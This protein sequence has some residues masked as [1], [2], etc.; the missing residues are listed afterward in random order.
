MAQI[1]YQNPNGGSWHTAN[2]WDLKRV[3]GPG[4]DVEIPVFAGSPVISI[5][6]NTSVKSITTNESVRMSGGTL[7]FERIA[8]LDGS[9]SIDA[10]TLNGGVFAR[11]NLIVQGSTI[12]IGSMTIGYDAT[13]SIRDYASITIPAAG[14]VQVEGNANLAVGS[15]IVFYSYYN[16]QQ[17]KVIVKGTLTADRS[18]FTT[19][20][21]N[22]FQS[23]AITIE[24]GGRM[25]AKSSV[26]SSP[27]VTFKPGALIGTTDLVNN[28][29]DTSIF[30]AA[31][32]IDKL[33][34]ASG[35]SDNRSF[36]E[37]YIWNGTLST[38]ELSLNKI[39]KDNTENLVYGFHQDFTVGRNATLRV[40]NG[41][42]IYVMIG[43]RL[44]IEGEAIFGRGS[45]VAFRPNYSPQ[46]PGIFVTGKMTANSS[47]FTTK[48]PNNYANG[49]IT[50]ESGGQFTA[51]SC[52]F[53]GPTISLKLGAKIGAKDFV[54]NVFDASLYL[55]ATSID[56]F[57]SVSGGSDNRSFY[58]INFWAATLVS[59]ETLT[60]RKIGKLSSLNLKYVFFEQFVVGASARLIVDPDVSVQI[61]NVG[62]TINGDANFLKRT[63]LDFYAGNATNRPTLSVNGTLTV[64]GLRFIAG[65]YANS[66]RLVISSTGVLDATDST[67][68][69][70][71][72]QFAPGS[73]IRIRSQ[74]GSLF[75]LG[76]AGLNA[77][78]NEVDTFSFTGG[79]TAFVSQT[80]KL[81]PAATFEL[82]ESSLYST[83]GSLL[84]ESSSPNAF[85]P[86]GRVIF[87]GNSSASNP[88]FLE[89]P[90][91]DFLLNAA[92]FNP[93]NYLFGAIEIA[94][95]RYVKLIDDSDNA[96]GIG[97]EAVYTN[98]L[99][100]RSN[101]TLD[102]NSLSSLHLYA[103]SILVEAGGRIING[104][105]APILEDS[106]PLTLGV[107]TP[108]QIDAQGNFDR[109][110][111]SARAGGSVS[112]RLNPGSI[113][114]PAPVAPQLGF[115]R[116]LLLDPNNN[117]I[118][119][120]FGSSLGALANIASTVLPSEGIYTV[121]VSAPQTSTATGNYVLTASDTTPNPRD[122]AIAIQ[123]NRTS[124]MAY[125]NSVTFTTT[126]KPLA[127]SGPDASGTVQF[128]IDGVAVGSPI[129]LVNQSAAIS[130]PILVAGNRKVT[131]AYSG[132]GKKYDAKVSAE[133]TQ[134][135][136]KAILQVTVDSKSKTAGEAIPAL[137]YQVSG[138]VNSE[139][140]SVV[141]GTPALT[142]APEAENRAGNYIIYAFL[143][144]L[145]S[146]NYTFQF[147]NATLAVLPAS[148]ADLRITS[149][150]VQ[151][152]K[153]GRVFVAPL[154]VR[155][156]DRF[157]NPILGRIVTFIAPETGPSGS[158]A[159]GVRTISLA[160]NSNGEASIVQFT[161]NLTPGSFVLLAEMSNLTARFQLTNNEQGAPLELS[162]SKSSISEKNGTATG[163]LRRNTPLGQTM[164]V[165][166]SSSD[167]LQATVPQT[168]TFEANSD[169]VE[170]AL[171]AVDEDV[172]DGDQLVT[173]LAASATASTSTAILVVDDEKVELNLLFSPITIPENG[174]TSTGTVFRNTPTTSDLAVSLTSPDRRYVDFPQTV[175]ILAGKKSANFLAK[176]IDDSIATNNRIVEVTASATGHP[177]VTRQLE[178]VD[179]ERAEL[180]FELQPTAS[181]NAASVTALL[182]RNTSTTGAITVSLSSD[183]AGKIEIPQSITIPDGSDVASFQI[184]IRNDSIAAGDVLATLTAK[185]PG[186]INA[187]ASITV[188]DDES[189]ILLLKTSKLVLREDAGTAQFELSRNTPTNV[190]L[191]VKLQS[192]LPSQLELPETITIPAGTSSITFAANIVDDNLLDGTQIVRVQATSPSYI[193]ASQD[194]EI[195]DYETLTLALAN[196]SISE[197]DGATIGTIT[198]SNS[199]TNLPIDVSI[200]VDDRISAGLPKSVT[201]PANAKSV[202][203]AINSI[204][205]LVLNGTRT[206]R[207]TV[208]AAG[209]EGTQSTLQILDY[210]PL[211]IT[212]E[213][214]VISERGGQTTATVSRGVA[215]T[216][217]PLVVELS[218][219]DVSEITV[220]TRV[221]IP[222]G[223]ASVT[224]QVNAKDDAILDGSQSVRIKAS[225]VGFVDGL[226]TMTVTDFEQL[227]L[228]LDK[229]VIDERGGKALTTLTRSDI[230][231]LSELT[232]S[233]T[234]N[235][236]TEV[237][238]PATVKFLAGEKS[239]QFQISAI[240]DVE[241]DG[242]QQ[243]RII[244]IAA[245]YESDTKL[246]EV[247][248]DEVL[249]P[250]FNPVNPLDAD[251]DNTISPLDVLVI[252]NHL[253][254][255]GS[256]QLTLPWTG[257][258]LDT[259]GDDSVSPLDV[260]TVINYLNGRSSGAGE[261]EQLS[262]SSDS[263]FV[264]DI[265]VSTLSPSVDFENERRRLGSVDSFFGRLGRQ[266][267]KGRI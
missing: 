90:S 96:S 46:Q 209:Y 54:D 49:A 262:S 170:F 163:T 115:A 195:H 125:G 148:P 184:G 3:P 9:F 97:K 252:I 7:Q 253:N 147:V 6:S 160:T 208:A 73:T 114:Q 109:W 79:A 18:T 71:D 200:D 134:I 95:N 197:F 59:Q 98:A 167:I 48:T 249:H 217:L 32:S 106:G 93:D 5:T 174:G 22:N 240:N 228:T 261:G 226:L 70:V 221:E 27:I 203:F 24:S 150:G 135:V 210:E 241:F 8:Q 25:I 92:G 80:L 45:N 245:G 256:G 162:F 232:V 190:S 87:A 128:K 152:T 83:T 201:I 107:P 51:T 183:Q 119:S 180:R 38:G 215:D 33:S 58:D 62:L 53:D 169:V 65:N 179:D 193:S 165:S 43:S 267:Y 120:A 121:I 47:T 143:G 4:D 175:T 42:R 204:D 52:L 198:R 173:I 159:I 130:L 151:S 230:D 212:T 40:N 229:T 99:I 236:S 211:V 156:E 113:E 102:L 20:T 63:I 127:A 138:F 123:S 172:A 74:N 260:L 177:S 86:S 166:L 39:G 188:I 154:R 110:T 181:E 19:N 266:A 145:S 140:A 101:A 133:F 233:I 139:S 247:T 108:G 155:L 164:T 246:L 237:K 132:D 224:F 255:F 57:S 66:G 254:S 251:G 238:I 153:A 30:I 105:V 81:A 137:T 100:V 16:P 136:S 213:T 196:L 77:V 205:D 2:D 131:V 168:V 89:A 235:D 158:F 265:S 1:K 36:R 84:V 239:I 149:G 214:D 60:L 67:F 142:V 189:P 199:D 35:G 124:G 26:F 69:H 12:T 10:G 50:I 141:R 234:T 144:T 23:G 111:F 75:N 122:T 216:S 182:R 17:P 250:W 244:A 176:A 263:S 219:N 129:P 14:I 242:P 202:Q 61:R 225:S 82:S 227:V 37:I 220:P 194:L 161:S 112:I 192:S 207:I 231:L 78:L 248:D 185:A 257:K 187:T 31:S 88:Q 13:M 243:V 68:P 218:V 264:R 146:D 223:Q 28:L 157:G 91:R 34:A 259:D 29:F 56:M 258:F 116:V 15:K 104:S 178:L 117:T 85:M 55:P 44:N 186:F 94:A 126:V 11:G 103:R 118:A 171:N 206:I 222:A 21:G 72:P 41:V 76:F 191:V 64:D